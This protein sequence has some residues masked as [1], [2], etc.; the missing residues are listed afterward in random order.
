MSA[1]TVR[2]RQGSDAWLAFRQNHI[3]ASDA[4]AIVGESPYSS[5][6]ALY[7]EK[8]E[9]SGP[10]DPDRERL[11]RIG[12]VL[13]PV[14]LRM[15]GVDRGTLVRKGRVLESREIPWLSCSLDGEVPGRIVEAKWSSSSRWDDGV[16]PDVRVQVTHQ[17]AVAGIPL[18]DVAVL[19][20]RGFTVYEVP[21]DSGLWDSILRME[22][23]FWDRVTRRDPPDP[24]AS[25]ASR[26]AL[27][28]LNPRDD[29]TILRADPVASEIVR[30]LLAA[31]ARAK[32]LEEE[33]GG[34]ENAVRFLL[35]EAS[36]MDGEGF[37]VTYRKAKDSVRVAWENYATALERMILA[38]AP[39]E[40]TKIEPLRSV[41]TTVQE[42]SRRLLVKAQE[43]QG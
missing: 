22:A 1:K 17:M 32:A 39:R 31:K 34:M 37:S 2:L 6:L 16:P 41:Y 8:T 33:I 3:G 12:H 30:D 26:K 42:G 7:L 25:E 36:G 18:A 29:G 38:A 21:F 43:V 19:T 20:P 11:F 23:D 24:D 28:R 27:S 9:G 40:A 15:Y 13:E 5:P 10:P 4:P 14:I 35:G